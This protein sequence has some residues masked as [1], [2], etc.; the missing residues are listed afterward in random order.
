MAMNLWK[1]ISPKSYQCAKCGKNILSVVPWLC[2]FGK[3][4]HPRCIRPLSKSNPTYCYTQQFLAYES[5][6]TPTTR[7]SLDNL[8]YL[9]AQTTQSVTKTT[10]IPTQKPT[11]IITFLPQWSASTTDDKLTFLANIFVN[12]VN[13]GTPENKLLQQTVSSNSTNIATNS[14]NI[15]NNTTEIRALKHESNSIPQLTNPNNLDHI[16]NQFYH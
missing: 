5:T 8:I 10:T 6:L 1:S 4:Y 11:N 12:H 3:E 13:T 15:Q 16:M 2:T 7:E 9:I 14:T